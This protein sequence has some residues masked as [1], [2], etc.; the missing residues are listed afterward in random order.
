MFNGCLLLPTIYLIIITEMFS[1]TSRISRWRGVAVFKFGLHSKKKIN[2]ALK[3]LIGSFTLSQ[4][5]DLVLQG[6]PVKGA[7]KD[8]HATVL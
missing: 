8:H 2:V 5:S 1:H 4:I 6:T 7:S 3:D